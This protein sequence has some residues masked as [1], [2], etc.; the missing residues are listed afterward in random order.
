[1]I[2]IHNRFVFIRHIRFTSLFLLSARYGHT[3]VKATDTTDP[4]IIKLSKWVNTQRGQYWKYVKGE[5]SC[6]NDERVAALENLGFEWRLNPG[7]VRKGPAPDTIAKFQEI[8]QNQEG[9]TLDDDVKWSTS[10][11][12]GRDK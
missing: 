2:L 4:K 9:G 12:L 6:M 5:K 3:R 1:M 10:E 8:E 7:R 11:L